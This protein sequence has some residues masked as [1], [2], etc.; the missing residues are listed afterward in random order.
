MKGFLKAHGKRLRNWSLI[1]M[2]V[3]PFLLYGAALSGP[4]WLLNVLL[5]L[6]GLSMLIALKVG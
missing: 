2:V 6:M 3:I 5:G 1:G 4:G